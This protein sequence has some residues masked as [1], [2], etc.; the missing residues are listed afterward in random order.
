MGTE[1]KEKVGEKSSDHRRRKAADEEI[2][3]Y[4]T[5]A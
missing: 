5:R 1:P 4:E 3:A 2:R